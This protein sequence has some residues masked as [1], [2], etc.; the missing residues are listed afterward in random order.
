MRVPLVSLFTPEIRY[1]LS[2]EIEGM[3]FPVFHNFYHIRIFQFFP[4]ADR[5]YEC[6]YFNTGLFEAGSQKVYLCGIDKRLISLNI[7]DNFRLRM[8]Q[9]YCLR[10]TVRSA[11]MSAGG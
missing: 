4:A 11:L 1:W 6:C 2:A 7:D 3:I 8:Q 9:L 5:F 10:A